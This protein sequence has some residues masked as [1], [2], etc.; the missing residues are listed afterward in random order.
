MNCAHRRM[1]RFE[2]VIKT[3]NISNS[4][5]IGVSVALHKSVYRWRS[6]REGGETAHFD[7]AIKKVRN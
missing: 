4:K 6:G 5:R 7:D 3:T 2:F 1:E